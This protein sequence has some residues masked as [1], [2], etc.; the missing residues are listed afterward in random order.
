MGI[1]RIFIKYTSIYLSIVFVFLSIWLER[2]FGSVSLSQLVY[3]TTY[4]SNGLFTADPEYISSFIRSVL[5]A[6]VY[7]TALLWILE[8][9]V[10]VNKRTR[11]IL[12]LKR[13]TL[14]L[15]RVTQGLKRA[16]NLVISPITDR[17]ST[18]NIPTVHHSKG[19]PIRYSLIIFFSGFFFF[20][21]NI[22]SVSSMNN[23]FAVEVDH[24][25]SM[26]VA[27]T[28][29]PLKQKKLKNLI[30]IYV[31]SLES[32]Y[33]LN[34]VVGRNLLSPLTSLEKNQGTF[35]FS[36]FSQ[37]GGTGWTI[38]G[39]VS[40]HCGVPLQ[41][42]SIFDGNEQ[43]EHASSFLP[44]ATCLGDILS[45][46]GYKNV[47]MRGA[48][49]EFA[50]TDNFLKS[51]G[52][53]ELYGR[54]HW[55]K[56]GYQKQHFNNWGLYDDDLFYEARLKLGS[57]MQENQR[58][59][60]TLLT[61]DMHPPNGFLNKD[62]GR[63]GFKGF[64]GVIECTALQIADFIG[65][66]EKSGWSDD[67]QIIVMGDHLAF[68][69]GPLDSKYGISNSERSIFNLFISE[70]DRLTKTRD[71]VTHFDMFPTILEFIGFDVPNGRFGLGYSALSND[72]NIANDEYLEDLEAA[73]SGIGETYKALWLP[74][75][76]QKLKP[77]KSP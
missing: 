61:V 16:C 77:L 46:Y 44:N 29:V 27:P 71:S 68:G 39:I 14:G 72:S 62:C 49:M 30:L 56:K 10:F 33:A 24:F 65:F 18:I 26:Y 31:E 59:N 57:L 70:D 15:K 69:G 8:C 53:T 42:L 64:E 45:K 43:G 36:S 3:H 37:M 13:F 20:L 23:L 63:R 74:T 4:F 58:F 51:H 32:A 48:A 21:F 52:Y 6:S 19:F 1:L 67:I 75:Q 34:D 73:L 55:I 41:T 7:A 5:L 50:G 2:K 54:E 12:G 47:F 28:D 60:L 35:G 40:S 76:D 66:I 38:A 22:N 25:G 17:L 11:L 9:L